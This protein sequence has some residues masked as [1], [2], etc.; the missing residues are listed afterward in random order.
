MNKSFKIPVHVFLDTLYIGT[1]GLL[2]FQ[3]SVSKTVLDHIRLTRGLTLNYQG[4]SISHPWDVFV[5]NTKLLPVDGRSLILRG[6]NTQSL[7][8]YSGT[9]MIFTFSPCAF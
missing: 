1:Q 7:L 8:I 6:K 4:N 3:N 2:D 9:A 5:L